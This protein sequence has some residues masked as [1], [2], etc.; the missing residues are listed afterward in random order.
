MRFR[1]SGNKYLSVLSPRLVGR[2]GPL[3]CEGGVEDG[4]ED[5]DEDGDEEE[6]EEEVVA[7]IGRQRNKATRRQEI[8][9][10]TKR[11]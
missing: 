2:K 11:W 4:V 6:G 5:G 1:S 7:C 8:C 10:M 3:G 9:T